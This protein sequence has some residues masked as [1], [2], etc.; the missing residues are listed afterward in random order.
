MKA[1]GLLV[2][3]KIFEKLHFKNLFCDPATNFCNLSELFEQ[4]W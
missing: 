2:S 4:F 1:L 3:D